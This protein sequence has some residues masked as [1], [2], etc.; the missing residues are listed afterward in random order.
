MH[1]TWSTL[2]VVAVFVLV[3]PF[4]PRLAT[5]NQCDG[6]DLQCVEETNANRLHQA[7]IVRFPDISNQLPIFNLRNL[8]AALKDNELNSF[9]AASLSEALLTKGIFYLENVGMDV[10]LSAQIVRD[11]TKVYFDKPLSETE[12][13]RSQSGI[14]RGLSPLE[15]ESVAALLGNGN[16]TDICYKWTMGNS[17][18]LVNVWPEGDKAFEEEWMSYHD[19]M[20]EVAQRFMVTIAESLGTKTDELWQ[21]IINSS[22]ETN[23]RLLSYPDV[24]ADRCLENGPPERMAAHHDL[25]LVTLI[26]QTSAANGFVSLQGHFPGSAG[27]VGIPSVPGTLVVTCG[28][29]LSIIS[30]GRV[31]AT[32]HRVTVPTMA[33]GVGSARDTLA[34]FYQPHPGFKVKPPRDTDFD[35]G[36]VYPEEGIP[37]N[38]WFALAFANLRTA[39]S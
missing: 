9:A 7:D 20:L 13:L 3:K 10:E 36:I 2:L 5:A 21:N 28:E 33:K 23:I 16:H 18:T 38:E 17:E 35:T 29:V 24:P 14:P 4:H 22:G 31:E 11:H 39:K 30:G 37:F 15:S 25:D 27:W 12:D 8:E 26:H 32:T 6:K 1:H 19:D 34:L